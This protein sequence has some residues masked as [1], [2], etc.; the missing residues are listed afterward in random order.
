MSRKKLCGFII[1]L[2]LG[3][4]G[5]PLR[6]IQIHSVAVYSSAEQDEDQKEKLINR[7]NSYA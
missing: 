2:P 5:E 6:S 4:V 7:V 1:L 3:A